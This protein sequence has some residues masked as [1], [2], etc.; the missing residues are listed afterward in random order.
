MSGKRGNNEGSITKRSDGRYV[1]RITV[2]RDPKTGKLQRVSYYGQTRQ[3]A[4]RGGGQVDQ[5][6]E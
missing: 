1:A 4:A 3:E 6:F 2:G 5:S